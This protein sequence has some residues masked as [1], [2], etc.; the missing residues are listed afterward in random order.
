[1]DFIVA[2]LAMALF[3]A[4]SAAAQQP[5]LSDQ[6]GVHTV[7]VELFT[8]QGC[9][10]CPP[11]DRLLSEL[12]AESRDRVVPLAFH[13]DFWNHAGWTDPFSKR[14]WTDRQV[15]YSRALGVRNVYT[16]QAVVDGSAELVGSDANGMRAAIAAAA[17]KPAAAIALRLQPAA[18]EPG[19]RPVAAQGHASDPEGVERSAPRGGG[20][21][22][23]LP[24][25]RD[26]RGE[27]SGLAGSGG[28]RTMTS[29]TAPGHAIRVPGAAARMP[30]RI[31]TSSRPPCA[32]R[33][34]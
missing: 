14:E 5:T 26:P 17:A 3:T 31:R 23:G 4:D 24:L 30:G 32:R 6:P 2:A 12:G 29:H 7:V 34:R 20:F 1:M 9:S 28:P 27:R 16:P 11:A 33:C 19:R 18:A 22:A 25:A 21:S 13:V 8:S 10:S 15:G